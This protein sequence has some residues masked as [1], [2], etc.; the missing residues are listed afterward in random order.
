MNNIVFIGNSLAAVKAIEEIRKTNPSVAITMVTDGFYP[1]NRDKLFSYLS[2]EI[3][4]KQVLVRPESFY[5]ENN[6]R[7]IT[8][9]T[10]AR[11][12]FKRN[13]VFF[14]NKEQLE[15]DV[16]VLADLGVPRWPSLKGNHKEG[17]Y[18]SVRLKDVKSIAEQLPF[19]ETVAVQLSSMTG[20]KTL[21]ALSNLGKDIVVSAPSGALF[22][23]LLDAESASILKQLMEQSGIRLMLE[24]SIEEILGDTEAKAIRLKSGKVFATDMVI[25]DDIRLDTRILKESGLELSQTGCFQSNFKNVYLI[26]AFLN[27]FGNPDSNDYQAPSPLL[28]EQGTA[29]AQ[30][31]LGQPVSAGPS[32]DV[33]R[34]QL[35]GL[36][37][38]WAGK[39]SLEEGSR[40]FLKFDAQKNVYKKIF[41]RD[42]FLSG[43]I[44]FNAADSDCAKIIDV[45]EKKTNIQGLEERLL[46][47]D[48]DLAELV[49]VQ[50]PQ[51]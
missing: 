46:E 18:N 9:Q 39:T 50:Q 4:E 48:F 21:C 7:V 33:T 3:K 40:E 24:N 36:H 22:T 44:F 37:G 26:D 41:A 2:K 51:L 34:F 6:V 43:A 42:A 31:I 14:E 30:D 11:F 29:L 15:Y 8:D 49:K 16:L 12:N 13:Q 5:K 38:F 10:V 27:S 47:E 20:F 32:L 17:V 19:V 28:L 25:L 45:L 35:K 23:G 1:Y